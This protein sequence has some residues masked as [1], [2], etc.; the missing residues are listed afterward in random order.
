MVHTGPDPSQWNKGFV[1]LPRSPESVKATEWLVG[2]AF[3]TTDN[4]TPYLGS[5]GRRGLPHR[6]TNQ[7]V[8]PN[9]WTVPLW[10]LVW[11][12]RKRDST[13][14]AD[15]VDSG[16]RGGP[17]GPR[18]TTLLPGSLEVCRPASNGQ[19]GRPSQE[20]GRIGSTGGQEDQLSA[21]STVVPRRQQGRR[22]AV[23]QRRGV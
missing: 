15:C 10:Y 3:G 7:R 12:L 14:R 13:D 4:E 20:D 6:M 23:W 22:G 21:P 8:T 17:S 19:V 9:P 5:G 1:Y 16:N 2:T 11:F 18:T